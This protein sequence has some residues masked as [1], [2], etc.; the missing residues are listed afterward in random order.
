[1]EWRV[2][3]PREIAWDLCH[4]QCQGGWKWVDSVWRA[5]RKRGLWWLP[6]IERVRASSEHLCN[7]MMRPTAWARRRSNRRQTTTSTR[8]DYRCTRAS[9][10][11]QMKSTSMAAMEMWHISERKWYS[12]TSKR[13]HTKVAPATIPADNCL[14]LHSKTSATTRPWICFRLAMQCSIDIDPQTHDAHLYVHP[15]DHGGASGGGSGFRWRALTARRKQNRT[16]FAAWL[17]AGH[18]V[19]CVLIKNFSGF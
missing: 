12:S 11:D 8:R 1:M 18:G 13:N 10:L 4:L 9:R 6:L 15:G 14:F 7:M 19:M 3:V 16:W 17:V 5:R 2:H